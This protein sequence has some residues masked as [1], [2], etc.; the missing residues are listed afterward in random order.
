MDWSKVS[1]DEQKAEEYA[2]YWE[3]HDWGG[4]LKT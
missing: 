2:R 1:Y 4:Q 3:L